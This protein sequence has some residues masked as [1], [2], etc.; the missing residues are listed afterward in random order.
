MESCCGASWNGEKDETGR[1]GVRAA[2]ARVTS[3]PINFLNPRPGTPLGEQ[4]LTIE[5]CLK[6]LCMV[7][8]ANPSRTCAAPAAGSGPALDAV[9][10]ALSLQ[11]DLHERLPDDRG[12]ATMRTPG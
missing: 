10:R 12:N 2:A 11:L 5:A 8:F 9:A 3:I 1:L 6:V 4:P 7:R